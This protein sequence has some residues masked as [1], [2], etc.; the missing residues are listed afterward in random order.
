MGFVQP[1]HQ[2]AGTVVKMTMSYTA[3]PSFHFM[4]ECIMEFRHLKDDVLVESE[5]VWDIL[6]DKKNNEDYVHF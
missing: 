2:V 1:W 4:V 3:V 5:N 6:R